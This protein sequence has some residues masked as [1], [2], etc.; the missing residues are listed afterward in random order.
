MKF[1]V[2]RAMSVAFAIPALPVLAEETG[3]RVN[4]MP[5]AFVLPRPSVTEVNRGAAAIK[6][7]KNIQVPPEWVP[8]LNRAYEEY[9]MEGNHRPD[10]GF[11]LFAR[12]PS[13]EAAKLWLL[14]MESKA[15]NLEELFGYV[16]EAQQELVTGG[17]MADRFN[18]VSQAAIAPV[19]FLGKG[20]GKINSPPTSRRGLGDLEFYFLF[21]P[22]CPHC[23]HLAQ[24]LVGFPNVHPLQ[25]TDGEV[26]HWPGLPMSDR[27]T[28][29]TIEAYVKSGVKAGGVPVLAIYQSKTKNVLKLRGA[30]S[31]EEI[32]AAAV[33]VQNQAKPKW[34]YAG[35]INPSLMGADQLN[36]N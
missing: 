11:V 4:T 20:S 28:P 5:S 9:W 23:A 13:K 33:S 1:I 18:M 22:T 34:K 27:A 16:K 14:R 19:G 3:S 35:P 36:P 2:V 21:S 31:A 26:I 12:N 29:E 17:L 7:P 30:H 8:L 15:Q 25:V 6:I 32:L 24:S 10:A